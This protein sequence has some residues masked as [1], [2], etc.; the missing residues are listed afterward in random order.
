MFLESS[1]KSSMFIALKVLEEMEEI[2]EK[3]SKG[4][5]EE[6]T[7]RF[8]TVIPHNFGRQRPPVINTIEVLRS[9]MDMLTVR[10]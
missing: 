8:Y 2:L 1:M 5:L 4:S 9:K 6:L 10:I 3:K 7:S